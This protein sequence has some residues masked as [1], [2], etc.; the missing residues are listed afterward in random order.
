M[1]QPSQ[2]SPEPV[3]PA[4][5]NNGTRRTVLL[6]DNDPAL[7]DLCR[8]LVTKAGY[9]FLSARDGSQGLELLRR[10]RAD[11]V[12]L[13]AMLP[14]RDGYA[15]YRE[16]T[17]S[18]EY[19]HLRQ[20][21]VIMLAAP[22]GAAGRA[23]QAGEAGTRLQQLQKPFAGAELLRA[24]DQALAAHNHRERPPAPA[25]TNFGFENII[26]RNQRMREI[27][28]RIRKVAKTDANIL[29]YGESGT[30]K[31]LI[32]RSIHAHS[33]RAR[34]PFIAVDCVALPGNLLESELFGYEKGAFTGAV[35]AK[36][37]L[38]ELAH[39]GTFFLDEIT[40][41]NLDLQAKLLRVLQERQFRRLGGKDLIEVD[42]RVISATNR[43]PFAAV[44]DRALRHDLYYRLNVIPITL[45]PLRERKDDIPLLCQSFLEKFASANGTRVLEI[46]PEALACLVGY[47]W[48][49][50]VRELQNVMERVASLASGPRV[51]AA[52]LPGYLR[53]TVQMHSRVDDK[54]PVKHA[55][56]LPLREARQQ[57]VEKFEREYL[58]E[59]M[60]R[61]NGN[62]SRVARKA[63][64]HRMTIYRMLKHYD[65]TLS[66]RRAQ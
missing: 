32:A 16:L 60:N 21:P 3:I 30:G 38:L 34:G 58:I 57:W 45:P 36:R 6:I 13:D 47:S 2:T 26:G 63:G 1:M 44:K 55:I 33:Q 66:P 5:K 49:G 24:I 39:T 59:L 46:A 65:I 4:E 52:D 53:E 50:N 10:G 64:V 35:T 27:F 23:H 37:G 54:A 28:E 17:G 56:D 31:E 61:C 22:G 41:L 7:H 48:P 18:A 29:I 8:M 15:V 43:E 12:L 40:E 51:E 20:V 62:I 9:D 25:G 19:A 11:V 42:M 14:D